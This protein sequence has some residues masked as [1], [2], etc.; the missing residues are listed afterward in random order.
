MRGAA[1][2]STG[3][4]ARARAIQSTFAD[5]KRSPPGGVCHKIVL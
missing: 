2:S 1:L 5:F 4:S 3:A